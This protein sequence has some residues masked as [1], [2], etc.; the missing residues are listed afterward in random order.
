MDDFDLICHIAFDKKPLTRVERVNN[1]KK[2]DYL[3]KY[4]GVARKVLEGLLDK[5]ATDGIGDL[6]SIEFLEN[7]PFRQY[8]SPMKIANEFGGKLQLQNALH[9]LQRERYAD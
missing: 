9:D 6:E 4:E 2:R 1:V 5:Y 3:N 8:G 7:D